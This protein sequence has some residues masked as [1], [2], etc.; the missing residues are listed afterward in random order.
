MF[1]VSIARFWTRT[2]WPCNSIDAEIN[3]Y[4]VNS[5][6]TLFVWLVAYPSCLKTL[7]NVNMLPFH[8]HL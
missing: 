8:Q 7:I 6:K 2:R 3:N 4:L 1:S 5:S